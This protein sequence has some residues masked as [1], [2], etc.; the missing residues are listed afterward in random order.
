V[1]GFYFF[2]Q[3]SETI[4]LDISVDMALKYIVSMG[5]ASTAEKHPL[6]GHVKTA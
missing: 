5:V 6:H 1:N 3:K 2:V 4:E